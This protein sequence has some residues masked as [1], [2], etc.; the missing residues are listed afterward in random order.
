MIS[1]SAFWKKS[2][3][4]QVARLK[5]EALPVDFSEITAEAAG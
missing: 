5:S 1:L 2:L 3:I 4:R